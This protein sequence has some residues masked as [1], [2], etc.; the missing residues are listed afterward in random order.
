MHSHGLELYLLH[1]MAVHFP[2]ALLTLGLAVCAVETRRGRPAWVTEAVSWLLWLGTAS[3]WAAMGLGLLAE[4]TAEHVPLAWETLEHHEE[5]AYWTVGL[6]TALSLWRF[7]QRRG[8]YQAGRKLRLAF[9]AAWLGAFAVLA[10]TAE[11]G[12][13]LVYTHGMGVSFDE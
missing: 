5:L 1:P 8:G 11:H 2:L 7:W 13:E 12:G 10:A 4:R 6:F 9:L 3:A